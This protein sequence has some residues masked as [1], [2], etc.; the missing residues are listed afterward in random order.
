MA[1]TDLSTFALAFGVVW[2]GLAAY[3]VWLHRQQVRL[4]RELHDFRARLK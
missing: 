3:L 2:G 1:S 4:A